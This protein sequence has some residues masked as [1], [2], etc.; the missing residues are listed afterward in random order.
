[1]A[2]NQMRGQLQV[3]SDIGIRGN[4][5]TNIQPLPS[6]GIDSAMNAVAQQFAGI[7]ERIG[8]MAD[9]AAAREGTEAGRVAGLD[10]EFRTM[11]THTIRGDA[12]DKA[13]L[14]VA[15]T[16]LRQEVD[17]QFDTAYT[18]HAGDATKLNASLNASQAGIL[19]HTPDEL[20]PQLQQ[21]MHGKRLAFSREQARKAAAEAAAASKAAM[22][23]QVS[24]T[25]KGLHQ[26]A[27]ALGLDAEADAALAIDVASLHKTLGRRG[28]DGALLVN[29][30]QAAKYMDGVKETVATARLTGAFARLPSLA[31]KE[32]FLKELDAD[33]AGS[34]G[35]AKVYDL[36]GF[37]RIKGALESDLRAARAEQSAQ[38]RAV[39]ADVGAV[40]KMAE[41]GFA[42]APA[43]LSGLKA[44]VIAA[45]D[46]ETAQTMQTVEDTIAW[47]SAA[48]RAT[49]AE[50]DQ[51]VQAETVRMKQDGATP[52]GVA[53]L[54]MANGLLDEMRRELKQDPLGWADR[55]GVLQ[56][57]PIDASSPDRL[58]ATFKAR[59]AQAETVSQLYGQEPQYLRP[60]ER[61]Q[62]AI[63]IGQGGEGAIAS[64]ASLANAAGDRAPKVMAEVSQDAPVAAML[65]GHVV[66][67]GITPL[68]TDAA[69][70]I[71]LL[72]TDGV[73]PMAPSAAVSRAELTSAAGTALQAMPKAESAAIAL[74]NAAYEV[75]ARRKGL[76]DF[77]SDTWRVALREVLGQRTIAGETYGGIYAQGT[78]GGN[79]VV[80]PPNIKQDAFGDVIEAV[81]MDDLVASNGQPVDAQ[82]EPVSIAT[83]QRARLIS[84]G[85]GQYWLAAGDVEGGDPQWIK[86]AGADEPYVLD[87][88]KLEPRLKSRLPAAYLG[89]H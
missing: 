2:N 18:K 23:Q 43:E 63:Q 48:R 60:D 59:A 35:L 67:A 62:L 21:L 27:Y 28:P 7:G 78:W 26:R 46:A 44:R 8:Q 38:T 58:S 33:F 31:A 13:G 81:R 36:Q 66:E 57:A 55:T 84:V 71:A 54:D 17:H 29:P 11:R 42:P 3:A 82:G 19:A 49:P 53:R 10:P 40:A 89:G 5:E 77:D 22:E 50:L 85:A 15:E 79:E 32:Q 61:R 76:T 41:K 75:R 51:F 34:R 80:V 24:D 88:G 87:L 56:L 65:G 16:R 25:L 4:S 74:A 47:Q 69:D 14:D 86:R 73:K 72:K 6:S 39:A 1:M 20:R 12:F 45:G 30:G 83:V 52:Q 64:L 68:A 37:E 9:R 70:G